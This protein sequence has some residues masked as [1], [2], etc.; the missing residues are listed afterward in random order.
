M[1]NRANVDRGVYEQDGAF[2][3]N[4]IL[5]ARKFSSSV[6]Q[7]GVISTLEL[8]MASNPSVA[9]AVIES[10]S[11]SAADVPEFTVEDLKTLCMSIVKKIESHCGG[12]V[13][14]KHQENHYPY[15]YGKWKDL[16]PLTDTEVLFIH[17]TAYDFLVD[18]KEGKDIL[19][20]DKSPFEDRV[21]NL[22]RAALAQRSLWGFNPW[23]ESGMAEL[24]YT[25]L[26]YKRIFLE[27]G[28]SASNISAN[29][30]ARLLSSFENFWPSRFYN[31]LRSERDLDLSWSSCAIRTFSLCG[32][33][34]KR[35]RDIQGPENFT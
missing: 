34:T 14:F 3:L 7:R 18:T 25:R 20:T 13:E 26:W 17:R 21:I 12:L 22:L 6:F 28:C 5:E 30:T 9:A 4:L 33:Q 2:F 29:K 31:G 10:E 35:I 1:W 8:M 15:H 27:I 19:V 23:C 11:P 24:F 16:I 32:S